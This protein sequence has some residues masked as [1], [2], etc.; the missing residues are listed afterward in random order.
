[1]SYDSI[2]RR[3]ALK[4]A[5]GVAAGLGGFSHLGVVRGSDL[6]E[7]PT[8]V[9]GGKVIKTKKVPKQWYNHTKR[10]HKKVK[11]VQSN[12]LSKN[13]VLAVGL[14]RSKSRF[15][16][17]K[18]S[19][20][21]IGVDPEGVEG[22]LPSHVDGL[23]VETEEIENPEPEYCG[24][25]GY[26]LL[27]EPIPGGVVNESDFA[28]E[29][30][31]SGTSC[32]PVHKNGNTFMLT[33]SHTW[34]DSDD[35]A[36]PDNCEY[37][38]FE[39]YSQFFEPV[40]E[41]RRYYPDGDFAL[42]DSASYDKGFIDEIKEETNQDEDKRPPVGGH[43]TQEAVEDFK[44]EGK[45]I[46]KK[47][48][49]TGLQS[50]EVEGTKIHGQLPEHGDGFPDDVTDR[51]PYCI[52]FGGEGIKCSVDETSA[53]DSGGPIYAMDTY[54]SID[55]AVVLGMH[56]VGFNDTNKPKYDCNNNEDIHG[57]TLDSSMY[58]LHNEYGWDIGLDL[59]EY[60]SPP[61]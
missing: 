51:I 23:P 27:G 53:G 19:Q 57:K 5:G 60:N 15:G 1:M 34:W 58:Y 43:Y 30:H 47:G 42:C 52:T 6:V 2:D 18:G 55:V 31:I 22:N 50:G 40:G 24:D 7:I 39:K 14:S 12:Q 4:T 29:G 17:K 21:W 13:G 8:V 25:T 38:R 46:K 49:T 10:S 35:P 20:I 48:I 3:T 44:S 36:L 33:A 54:L 61:S 37:I 28:E 26:T 56:S 11:N 45:E 9:S 41:V 59:T 32:V 16:G